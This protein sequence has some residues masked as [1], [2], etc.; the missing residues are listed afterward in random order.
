MT[1][2]QYRRNR[3]EPKARK[4]IIKENKLSADLLYFIEMSQD[5]WKMCDLMDNF[6]CSYDAMKNA[7]D[8]L[9]YI[10]KI[11]INPKSTRHRKYYLDPQYVKIRNME[12][13]PEEKKSSARDTILS[14]EPTIISADV[15]KVIEEEIARLAVVKMASDLNKDHKN[16]MMLSVQ[17]KHLVIM[18]TPTKTPYQTIKEFLKHINT[19]Y[20]FELDGETESYE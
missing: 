14:L 18:Y 10:G 4:Q 13:E 1:L 7:L 11:A 16:N 20:V 15:E 3:L 12:K 9:I 8:W 17:D 2:D 6:E 5:A 19:E